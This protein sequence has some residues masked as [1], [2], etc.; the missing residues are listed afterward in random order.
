MNTS[1]KTTIEQL[2]IQLLDAMRHANVETLDK[3]IHPD[4]LFNSAMGQTV[5]KEIDLQSYSSGLMKVDSISASDQQINIIGDTAV[6]AVTIDMNGEYGVQPISG[7][8]RF[9]RVWKQFDNSW[10]VIAGS[11]VMI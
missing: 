5:T 8:V 4:L 7:K 10:Q 6:V 1:D 2:E 9:L 3:L 11:S